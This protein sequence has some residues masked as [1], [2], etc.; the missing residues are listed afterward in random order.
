MQIDC[1]YINLDSAIER[2]AAIERNLVE[3]T[4]SSDWS[5]QRLAAVDARDVARMGVPGTLRDAQKAC[6]LSHLKALE[7]SRDQPGHTLIAE[8]D[9]LFCPKS[10]TAIRQVV[11]KLA[12][13]SWDLLFADVGIPAPTDMVNL[14]Q[15][16]RYMVQSR[17]FG[18]LDLS[19]TQFVGSACYLVNRDSRMKVR[20]CVSRARDCSLPYDLFLRDRIS[21]GELKA[22]AIFPF[23]TSLSSLAESSS[24]QLQ[25]EQEHLQNLA[26]NAFRRLTWIGAGGEAV[27]KSLDKVRPDYTDQETGTFLKILGIVLSANFSPI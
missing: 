27:D 24:I 10:E 21:K 23:A 14:F 13:D 20:E 25:Q 11:A 17:Q 22:F 8:D 16:R 9:A 3:C 1:I 7:M 18:A 12:P 5:A 4:F 15:L 19:K 26:W 6:I 2:R